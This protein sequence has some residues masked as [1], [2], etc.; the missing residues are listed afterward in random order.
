MAANPATTFIA[1]HVAGVAEDLDG[2]ER[3]LGAYPDLLV[4]IAARI[5]ELGRQPRRTRQLI[6]RHADRVLFG[7]KSFHPAWK[8]SLIHI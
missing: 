4:D 6:V 2:V 5:A 3:W 1:A 8:L 7:P